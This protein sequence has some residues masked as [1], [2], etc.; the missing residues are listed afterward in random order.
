MD[1]QAFE[2][3]GIRNIHSVF[4]RG[5]RGETL[6]REGHMGQKLESVRDAGVK[7][8]VDFRTADHNVRFARRCADVGIVYRHIPIDSHFPEVDEVLFLQRRRRFLASNREM[9]EKYKDVVINPIIKAVQEQ[10]DGRSREVWQ[11]GMS[12]GCR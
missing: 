7:V 8:V 6:A 2:R 9:A 1:V 5:V 12:Y 3:F 11:D 10:A 4:G